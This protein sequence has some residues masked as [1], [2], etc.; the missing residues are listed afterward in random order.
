MGEV[1]VSFVFRGSVW[2]CY[3]FWGFWWFGG[4]A[5]WKE[6]GGSVVV[7]AF[8]KLKNKGGVYVFDDACWFVL[9]FPWGFCMFRL[10]S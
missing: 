3:Y 1:V 8:G 10:Q 7:D 2:G 6:G 9:F 5:G 4:F